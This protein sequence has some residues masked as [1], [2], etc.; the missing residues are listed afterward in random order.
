MGEPFQELE[1]GLIARVFFGHE[2]ELV[3]GQAGAGGDGTEV[4]TF[5]GGAEGRED[6]APPVAPDG[7]AQLDPEGGIGPGGE[8]E[9][10]VQPRWEALFAEADGNRTGGLARLPGARLRL[11]PGCLPRLFCSAAAASSWVALASVRGAMAART[12]SGPG[13]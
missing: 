7:F 5:G 11:R 1:F 2:G 6:D 3:A 4:L 9:R 13:A 12:A 8:G 10:R